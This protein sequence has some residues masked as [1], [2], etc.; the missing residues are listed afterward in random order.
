MSANDALGSYVDRIVEAFAVNHG[1]VSIT[2]EAD[3]ASLSRLPPRWVWRM[4][5][6]GISE[7]KG[8]TLLEAWCNLIRDGRARGHLTVGHGKAAAMCIAADVASELSKVPFHDHP[9]HPST[10]EAFHDNNGYGQRCPCE[11]D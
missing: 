3:L 8:G 2:F 6:R 1:L 4:T 10:C 9:S 5:V 11:D 7:G